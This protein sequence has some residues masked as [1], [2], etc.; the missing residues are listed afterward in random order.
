M[1]SHNV[2][3]SGE[4][5]ARPK[6][7]V[8]VLDDWQRIA[9]H[10]ADWSALSDRAE[11]VFFH[12][13]LG[14]PNDIVKALADF[15]IILAMRERTTFSNDVIAGLPRLK[16]FNM[17]GRRARGLDE[18]LRRGIIVSI[19]GGGEDGQDTAE[20]A[21]ALMLAAVRRIPEGD[22]SIKG[23]AFLENVPPGFR[24][25]GKTLG[26]LGLGLIGGHLAN[27]CRALGMDVIAWS[28][29]MTTDKAA[30]A[31]VEA[32]S[33]DDLFAR[34]DI[35]SLHLVL[36][37]E[38]EKIVGQAQLSR[39]RDGAILVNT[40]RAPLIDEKPLIDALQ[41]RRIQAAIDVFNEEPLP[42]DHP[43]RSAPNVVLTPHVGYG[44]REMYQIFYRNSIENTLAFLDGAPIRQY[45]F[46][47][48]LM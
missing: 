47:R 3:Y 44:T 8:A 9:E 41:N 36:S 4:P 40:S 30:A 31:G 12:Q 22:A 48:H 43:L 38:T 24:M 25:A 16:F 39:M 45:S 20:H 37:P 27:Y 19:T 26:I 17:T 5:Q 29:S 7:R 14:T 18:M 35:V 15:D 1:L 21:L 28:R 6:T 42:A 11:V 23:G 33:I 2:D 10:S 34:S 46:D 32:V 13:P